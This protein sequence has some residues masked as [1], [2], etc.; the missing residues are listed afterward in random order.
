MKLAV[1]LA[2]GDRD[3]LFDND[4]D[5]DG[6]Q[7]IVKLLLIDSDGETLNED[8]A[9]ALVAEELADWLPEMEALWL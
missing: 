4:P 2:D 1:P 3:P 6:D 8:D 9:E 5:K 7:D